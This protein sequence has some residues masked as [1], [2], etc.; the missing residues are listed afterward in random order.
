LDKA[1]YHDAFFIPGIS[2]LEAISLK[3]IL[4]SPKSL[5]YPRFR[6]HLKQRLTIRVEY[7]GGFF[8]RAITDV[9]ANVFLKT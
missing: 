3:Q 6:P 5:K 2:P 4:H 8:A 9:F 1:L 7:L